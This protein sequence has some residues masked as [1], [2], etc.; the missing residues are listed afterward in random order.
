MRGSDDLRWDFRSEIVASLKVSKIIKMK[1]ENCC[2]LMRKNMLPL[3]NTQ[4]NDKRYL[5]R[6]TDELTYLEPGLN[7]ERNLST[8]L[9][10]KFYKSEHQFNCKKDLFQGIEQIYSLKSMYDLHGILD[11]KRNRAS[12]D[13]SYGVKY[14]LWPNR[15]T[16]K[17]D[18]VKSIFENT[19]LPLNFEVINSTVGNG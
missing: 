6:F 18:R 7:L 19:L 14:I 9:K 16:P 5:W 10:K 17:V 13:Q 11:W 12:K 4:T 15:A 8:I 1:S 3:L 2:S